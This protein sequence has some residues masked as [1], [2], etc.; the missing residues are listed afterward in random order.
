MKAFKVCEKMPAAVCLVP[1]HYD[2][3]KRPAARQS[4]DALVQYRAHVTHP[5][6]EFNDAFKTETDGSPKCKL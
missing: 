1:V 5:A 3:G 6:V 4:Y 2:A